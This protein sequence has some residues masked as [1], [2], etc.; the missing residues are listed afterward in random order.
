META[1]G[2]RAFNPVDDRAGMGIRDCFAFR[3]F[4]AFYLPVGSPRR[5]DRGQP[6]GELA[7]AVTAGG[8]GEAA[9]GLDGLAM[10]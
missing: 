5:L 8:A 3:L 9:L 6:V 1:L 10:T 7:A 4:K 2:A